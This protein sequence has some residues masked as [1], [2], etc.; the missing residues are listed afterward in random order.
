MTDNVI[1]LEIRDLNDIPAMLRFWADRIESGETDATSA[2]LVVPQDD[3]YPIVAGFGEHLG[4]LGNIAVME[5]AKQ[6]FIDYLTA[7]S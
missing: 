1:H 2:F 3:D 5:L 4:D 6:F 7:R